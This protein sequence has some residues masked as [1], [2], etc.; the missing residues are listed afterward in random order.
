M[1]L[2][3][4]FSSVYASFFSLV[5]LIILFESRYSP[6]KTIRLTFSLMIPLLLLNTVMLFLLGPQ[7]MSTLLLLTCSLPSLIF[8]WV[9][10]KYRDGRLLFTFC[11]ADTL[12]L[13]IMHITTVLDFF[14]GNSYIFTAAARLILC[15]LLAWIIYRWVRPLYRELQKN[16][17]KGWYVFAAIALI[18][19]IVLSLSMSVPTMITERLNQLPAMILLLILMPAIYIQIFLTLCHQQK[20]HEM[21]EE[22]NILRLQVLGMTSRIEELAAADEKFRTERHDFRHQLQVIAG[23]AEQGEYDRLRQVIRDYTDTVRESAVRRYCSN[24]VIDTVLA[25]YLQKAEDRGIQVCTAISFPETLPV[26]DTE[27]ATVFSNAIENAINACESVEPDKRMIEV[28][29]LTSP[30]FMLQISNSYTGTVEFNENGI[31][32]SRED[33]HGFGTRSIA[34]F[35]NKNNAFYEFKTTEEKFQLRISF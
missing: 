24:P 29:V 6:K 7:K 31:P 17:T 26:N 3:R 12:V 22:D 13:E 30:R 11:L 28:K 33:G 21:T 16:V 1:T 8:F 20:L 9:L 5:I 14:L 32:V 23:L 15:P 34:A 2:L 35:C 27:L 4:D 25:S 19:Y 10:A 18:F